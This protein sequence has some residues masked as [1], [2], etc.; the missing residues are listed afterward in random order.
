MDSFDKASA[1]FVAWLISSGADVSNKIELKDL[2]DIE[3]GRG[4]GKH[5]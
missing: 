3:A 4:V 1:A 5:F 2:R